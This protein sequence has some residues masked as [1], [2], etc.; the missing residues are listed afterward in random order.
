VT[1]G[2]ITAGQ[3]ELPKT[4]QDSLIRQS[5]G[6]NTARQQEM[7]KTPQDSSLREYRLKHCRTARDA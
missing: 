1:I 3:Q 7:P 2:L 5:I 6:L 4:P